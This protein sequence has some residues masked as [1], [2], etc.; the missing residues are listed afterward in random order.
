[1]TQATQQTQKDQTALP[2]GVA[3]IAVASDKETT[4]EKW[5]HRTTLLTNFVGT[6]ISSGLIAFGILENKWYQ[7]NAT[8]KMEKWKLFGKEF[9]KQ[10]AKDFNNTFWLMQGGN[11]MLI[12][13][14]YLEK[15]KKSIVQFFNKKFGNTEE[16]EAYELRHRD[17]PK[18]SW[19][20]FIKGRLVAFGVVWGSFTLAGK[21]MGKHMD[22]FEKGTGERFAKA[23]K[24]EAY[25]KTPDGSI[26]MDI[27]AQG[28]EFKVPTT[29]N[30]IGRM[31]SMDAFATATAV[32][33]LDIAAGFFSRHKQKD[34]IEPSQ[35][36][37]PA[38][39]KASMP[40]A[41]TTEDDTSSRQQNRT[42]STTIE[43]RGSYRDEREREKSEAA[44]AAL[45]YS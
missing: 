29:A 37:A 4:G 33:V 44:S 8:A 19:G 42:N 9:G 21:F 6:F 16:I 5:Y 10:G 14:H 38:I 26:R 25:E 31:F 30:K 43:S 24:K 39:A 7:E 45:S 20:D 2:E 41:S 32:G 12:P 11:L 40:S 28:N 35:P 3:P 18:I 15:H 34:K 22:A 23:L 13:M 1:M 27:D 36:T 17:T